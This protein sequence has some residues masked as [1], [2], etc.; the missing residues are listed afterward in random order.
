[1]TTQTSASTR[2]RLQNSDLA[3]I[4]PHLSH[5]SSFQ[6]LSKEG[7]INYSWIYLQNT[8]CC[9][10]QDMLSNTNLHLGIESSPRCPCLKE[11][12]TLTKEE[13]VVAALGGHLKL[14]DKNILLKI[15]HTSD[16]GLRWI[17]LGLTWSTSVYAHTYVSCHGRKETSSLPKS[18]DYILEQWLN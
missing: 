13:A 1:M 18:K 2:S 4:T 12:C 11:H 14:E 3:K 16:I 10:L 6:P 15:L 17:E 7:L 9:F 8:H 5:V